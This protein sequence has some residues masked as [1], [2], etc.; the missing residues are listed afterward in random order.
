MRSRVPLFLVLFFLAAL[1]G[2]AAYRMSVW[3]PAWDSKAV[4][5]LQQQAGN[6]DEANPGWYAAMADGSV[7]KNWNA[8]DPKLR[9][10]LSGVELLPTIKNYN[11]D[12]GF[13]GALAETI[14]SASVREQ[15]AEAIA[16][17]VVTN[18]F[19]GIDIDYERVPATSRGDFT[20]FVETLAAKLHA[21][22]KK[23][24]VTVH[25]KTREESRSGPGAQDWAA[26]GA[27]A[28]SVKIMAYDYHWSTS[29]AGA[30]APLSWLEQVAAYAASTI[31]AGKAIVGL[32]WYGYDWLA[33][34]AETVTYSDAMTRAQNVGATVGR[35]ANGEA[36]F[37]YG[38]RTVFFQDATSYQR[39]IEAIIAR[40][41][42]IGGFAHWRVGAEDPAVWDVIGQLRA[43]GRTPVEAPAK[44]FAISGPAQIAVTAGTTASAAFSYIA[45]NGFDEQVNVTATVLDAFGG[46]ASLS[47]PRIARTGSTSLSVTVPA[48]T[49]PGIYRL[50]LKMSGATV[51]HEQVVRMVVAAPPV[52]ETPRDFALTTTPQINIRPGSR[53]TL[54]VTLTPIDGFTGIATMSA[55][56]LD[57]FPGSVTPSVTNVNAGQTLLVTLTTPVPTPSRTYRL[58]LTATS[59]SI[60]RT[61]IVNVVVSPTKRRAVR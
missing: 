7:T 22:G 19:D 29:P 38:Q 50:T 48:M 12:G 8:E 61:R 16:Q 3:V 34:R 20:A 1:P 28:D 32:P 59:G 53:S 51:S 47:A 5:I 43:T 33:Q 27:A 55:R 46:T 36:T 57:G 15:H 52:V 10:A 17:L 54:G 44:D 58:E 2:Q 26:I 42:S 14:L 56:M 23:L 40:H 9:A 24:S 30:I 25:A 31:P 49:V 11:A 21:S 39:K 18:A 35:D 41:P 6:L 45:I 4:P 13:D 37:T 60:T